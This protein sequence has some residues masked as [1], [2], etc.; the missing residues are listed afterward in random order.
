MNLKRK[1]QAFSLIYVGQ[2]MLKIIRADL[3]GS[4]Y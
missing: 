3:S 1:K 2:E 4:P